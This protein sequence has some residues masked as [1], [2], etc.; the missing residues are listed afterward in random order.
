MI[1]AHVD[2]TTTGVLTQIYQGPSNKQTTATI[3]ITNRTSSTVK[4]RLS[5]TDT[6]SPDDSYWLLYDQPIFPNDTYT[7][8]VVVLA[9]SQYIFAQTDTLGVNVVAWGFQQ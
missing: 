3:R 9:T 5:I 7:E 6:A 2:L 8:G 1:L 4:V